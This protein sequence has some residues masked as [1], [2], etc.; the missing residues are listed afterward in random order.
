[1]G[2]PAC[3]LGLKHYLRPLCRLAL[4]F[5]AGAKSYNVPKYLCIYWA[6]K[7]CLYVTK[8]RRVAKKSPLTVITTSTDA[9]QNV[10]SSPP[11][12][13]LKKGD[14]MS[15]IITDG[16]EGTD[17]TTSIK[18]WSVEDN[19]RQSIANLFTHHLKSPPPK[20][21]NGKDGSLSKCISIYLMACQKGIHRLLVW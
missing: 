21:W 11:R 5:H 1:M 3:L 2:L 8:K 12:E 17:S 16:T 18:S 13:I 15:P 4:N 14:I 19:I 9:S 10:E 20:E 6:Q 7:K